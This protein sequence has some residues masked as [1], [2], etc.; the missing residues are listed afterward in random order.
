MDLSALTA[1]SP[2]DGRYRRQVSA[3]AP[4]FSEFGLIRY[5]VRIEIEYFIELCEW[6]IPQ[7]AGVDPATFPSLRALYENFTEAARCELKKLKQRQTTM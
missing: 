1:I 6:S 4:Y 2:V 5:R 7:L 3:L